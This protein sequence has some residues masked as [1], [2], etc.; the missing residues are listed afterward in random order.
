MLEA[1]FARMTGLSSSYVNVVVKNKKFDTVQRTFMGL[2][3]H[4][5]IE[6]VV[7]ENLRNG[8]VTTSETK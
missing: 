6:R 7:I 4:V 5:G 3:F 1:K 2:M 8:Q